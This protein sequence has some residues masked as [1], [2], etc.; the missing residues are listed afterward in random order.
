MTTPSIGIRSLAINFP[1][2]IRTNDYWLQKFPNIGSQKQRQ[3]KANPKLSSD[4]GLDI[5]LQEV[6]PY[7]PDPFRGSVNRHLLAE[8]ESS[9]TLEY[10][11]AQAA[12]AAAK[13]S[14]DEIDLMLVASLFPDAV[15]P[16]SAAVLAQELNLRCPAWNLESTCS[17]ALIALQTAQALVQTGT[18][19]HVL[20]VVSHI[21]SRCVNEADTLSWSMGDGAGAFVVGSL[22]PKQGILSTKIISTTATCK[23]YVHELVVDSQ[24]QPR[25]QT[26]TGENAS[27]LAETAVDCVRYCCQQAVRAAGVRLEQIDLFALNTPTA[28]YA[29]VCAKA[30]GIEPQR[31]MNLYAD[32][33]NIG[34]VFSVANLYHAVA[35]NKLCEDNLVLVYANGAGATAAATVMRWGDVALGAADALSMPQQHAVDLAVTEPVGVTNILAPE[36]RFAMIDAYLREQLA[37]VSFVSESEL[38]SQLLLTTVLDSLAAI[39]LRTHIETAWGVRVPMENFFGEHTLADL[40]Q[41]LLNQLAVAKLMS[42]ASVTKSAREIVRL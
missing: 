12:L 5:W 8:N 16:G 32:Y 28:W 41:F 11:A 10:R 42:S 3:A 34:P 40:T 24:G 9:Q 21:G 30:L 1:R 7:L 26:R 15:G 33:A 13:L 39:A 38:N 18:Y 31:V 17:S 35:A 4:N 29:N 6:T 36:Q 20:I 27:S 37:S 22:K 2:T 14:A 19:R 23:A 25:I